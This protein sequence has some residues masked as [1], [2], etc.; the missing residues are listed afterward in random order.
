[1][2]VGAV[3][4]DAPITAD[5]RAV[6]NVGLR[7]WPPGQR[8]LMAQQTLGRVCL[9]MHRLRGATFRFCR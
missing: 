1:M 5:R 9:F 4:D 3:R 6:I 2:V 7:H 8:W